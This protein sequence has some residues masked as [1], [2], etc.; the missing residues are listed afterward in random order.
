MEKQLKVED[1]VIARLEERVEELK[2]END[3][4]WHE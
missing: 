4:M 2:M 1:E 3:K